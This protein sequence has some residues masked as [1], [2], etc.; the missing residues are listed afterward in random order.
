MSCVC[1]CWKDKEIKLTCYRCNGIVTYLKTQ[2]INE[3]DE[4]KIKLDKLKKELKSK[5]IDIV[6]LKMD[7]RDLEAEINSSDN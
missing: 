1:Q 5:Q 2:T 3:E 4:I 6:T 7:I